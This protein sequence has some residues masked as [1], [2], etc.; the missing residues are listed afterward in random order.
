M[1]DVTE[2][3]ER[4]G[5]ELGID[6]DVDLTEAEAALDELEADEGP[7]GPFGFSSPE[8]SESD[9]WAALEEIGVEDAFADLGPQNEM[10]EVDLVF[11]DVA[12]DDGRDTGDLG[13]VLEVLRANPG[14]KLTL[15][16]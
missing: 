11:A 2:F 8:A 3:H 15:S 9:A 6:G 14:L 4:L 10:D 13:A 16:F 12:V 5:E 1:S 7:D